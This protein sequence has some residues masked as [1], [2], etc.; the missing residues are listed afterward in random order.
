MHDNVQTIIEKAKMLSSSIR[1]LAVTRRYNECRNK[2]N[3]DRNAQALYT[4]LVALG[5]ELNETIS[6]GGTVEQQRTTEYELMQ[7]ELELNPLVKDFIQSQKEYLE[8]LK[9]VIEKIKGPKSIS[10]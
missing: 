3:N 2:M 4:N 9:K 5:K 6:S 10:M 7:R 1:N 8:L